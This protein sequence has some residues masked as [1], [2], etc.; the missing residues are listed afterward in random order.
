MS[1]QLSNPF[2]PFK[3]LWDIVGAVV[4]LITSVLTL[5]VGVSLLTESKDKKKAKKIGFTPDEEP[6]AK[7]IEDELLDDLLEAPG[8]LDKSEEELRVMAKRMAVQKKLQV[9]AREMASG[10]K[11][12]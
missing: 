7:T 2:W 3:L 5:C 1:N 12:S 4:L 11:G 6:K 8:L 9:F 10:V